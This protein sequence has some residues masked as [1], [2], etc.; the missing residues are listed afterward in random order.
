MKVDKKRHSRRSYIRY[1]VS[2]SLFFAVIG[3]ST[4]ASAD[5][6][7]APTCSSEKVTELEEPPPPNVYMQLDQSGSMGF[8]EDSTGDNPLWRV[9]V[10]A[11]DNV[12]DPMQSDVRFGLG[13]FPCDWG[14]SQTGWGER[15][16]TAVETSDGWLPRWTYDWLPD[17]GYGIITDDGRFIELVHTTSRCHAGDRLFS[18]WQSR[19]DDLT[20]EPVPSR[21]FGAS[22]AAESDL[23]NYETIMGILRNDAWPLGL[24]P[25]TDAF[26]DIASSQS[27]NDPDYTSGA[28]MITDGFPNDPETSIQTACGLRG[29]HL[30]YVAGLGGATDTDFNNYMAAAAGTGSCT[31]GDPCEQAFDEG[32]TDCSG[33]FQANNQ[34]EFQ[35]VINEISDTLQCTFDVDTDHFGGNEPFEELEGYEVE[36]L[37][38]EDTVPLQHRSNPDAS[39]SGEGWFFPSESNRS[40]I[41][42]TPYYCNMVQEG[43]VESVTTRVGCD[44]RDAEGIEC[45]VVNPS[46][47]ECPLG[48]TMCSTGDEICVPYDP[49]DCPVSCDTLDVVGAPCHVDDDTDLVA[50]ELSGPEDVGATLEGEVNRCKVGAIACT[51]N[52]DGAPDLTCA[53]ALSPM[54]EVC[55]G[56]DNS[57]S[58]TVDDIDDSWLAFD[59]GSAPF[60]GSQWEDIDIDPQGQTCNYSSSLCVCDESRPNFAGDLD[61]DQSLEEE[62]QSYLADWDSSYCSCSPAVSP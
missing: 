2:A 38:S 34:T 42:L 35:N 16:N 30:T 49:E 37:T 4:T 17:W 52:P 24:T 56:R 25:I 36:M 54:P 53:Q 47:G 51:D 31:G 10:N 59:Q 55:D 60:G 12:I 3:F 11:L 20:E 44:C 50:S 58:G 39:P 9:A 28:I 23:N 1:A 61:P 57:C 15:D 33:A 32:R 43:D 7:M 41:T 13:L 5:W 46:D 21:R 22:E 19:F 40:E 26:A 48:E 29:E 18:D 62:V 8:L 45:S 27:M 14:S 6:N